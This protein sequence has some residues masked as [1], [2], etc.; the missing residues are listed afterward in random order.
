[1]TTEQ[2][3]HKH[4]KQANMTK[5]TCQCI[6][7]I[8][9]VIFV[10]ITL[11]P[12]PPH[13]GGSGPLLTAGTLGDT[14]GLTVLVGCLVVV[15]APEVDDV[16]GLV[17]G[18]DEDPEASV[19]TGVSQPDGLLVASTGTEPLLDNAEERSGSRKHQCLAGRAEVGKEM[20]ADIV[21]DFSSQTHI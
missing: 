13:P 1:M 4:R 2:V 10:V 15:A 7:C 21:K 6:T 19:R 12:N 20:M 16:G 8:T 17:S 5:I 18:A 3:V 11:G 9:V 14:A